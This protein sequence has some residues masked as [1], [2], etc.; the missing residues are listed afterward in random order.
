MIGRITVDLD[1]PT[2]NNVVELAQRVIKVVNGENAAEAAGAL[3]AVLTLIGKQSGAFTKADA[4]T[5]V[6]QSWGA[7]E[8]EPSA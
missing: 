4:L 7:I 2:T 8:C 1:A 5:A 3:V 6:E